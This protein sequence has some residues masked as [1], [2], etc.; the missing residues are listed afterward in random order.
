MFASAAAH[1]AAEAEAAQTGFHVSRKRLGLIGLRARM[2]EMIVFY[3]VALALL[4]AIVV[5][6]WQAAQVTPV[7]ERPRALESL[8]FKG[9]RLLRPEI[10]IACSGETYGNEK[11]ECLVAIARDGGID[12]TG[13]VRIVT[14]DMAGNG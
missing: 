13:P 14:F 4:A 5:P 11:P 1:T 6:A 7:T 9:D 2:D 10:D 12:R 3:V 8:A